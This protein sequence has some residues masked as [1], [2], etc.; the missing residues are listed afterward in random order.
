MTNDCDSECV[1]EA[2]THTHDYKRR[3]RHTPHTH[4]IAFGRE[5]RRL[6]VSDKECVC[7]CGGEKRINPSSARSCKRTD[8]L[9]FSFRKKN[10]K[11][12][13]KKM[14]D[15]RKKEEGRKEATDGR[16]DGRGCSVN[17]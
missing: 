12:K 7:E 14:K 2:R 13:K 5:G 4:Y 1:I 3:R 9:V 8:K 11:Y 17:K 10:K 15:E 6:V 16:T